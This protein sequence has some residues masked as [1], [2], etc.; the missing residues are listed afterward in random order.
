M[1]KILCPVDFSQASINA[2]EYALQLGETIGADLVEVTHCVFKAKKIQTDIRYTE[3]DEAEIKAQE[4][5]D[6]YKSRYSIKIGRSVFK[7]HPLDVLLPYIKAMGRNLIVV[8]TR[9]LTPVRNLTIGSFTEDL[10]FSTECPVLVIPEDHQF[11]RVENITLATDDQFISVKETLVPLSKLV[12]STDSKLHVVH[13]NQN[14]ESAIDSLANLDQF[15]GGMDYSFYS[16][17]VERTVTTTLNRFV[18]KQKSDILCM[19]HRD[20]GWMI[21]IFHK[22]KVKEELFHLQ[23]PLLVLSE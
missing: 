19:I 11:K 14:G 6:R 8:G 9:G 22:S 17:P 3:E 1:I 23:V 5:E 18:L 13:V 16:I 21:N 12:R 20:R 10:I 4:L 2:L 15:F 7:G